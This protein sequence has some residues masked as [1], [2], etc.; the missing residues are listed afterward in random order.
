MV[1]R[2]PVA[3]TLLYAAVARRDVGFH[4]DEGTDARLVRLFLELPRA[5]HVAV[6]GD[7]QSRLLEFESPP[8]QLID[9]IGAVE[10]RIFRVTVEMNEGHNL[11]ITSDGRDD[12]VALR[13]RFRR[14]Y[15][16]GSGQRMMGPVPGY[17]VLREIAP[18][19]A[20]VPTSVSTIAARVAGIHSMEV[21]PEALMVRRASS[22]P[23]RWPSR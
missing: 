21:I 10:E 12:A 16:P 19:I 23:M 14:P 20:S 6:V 8:D 17:R 7:G 22:E 11:K 15:K 3:F 18:L 4:P 5:M 13:I 2:L 9:S 1:I